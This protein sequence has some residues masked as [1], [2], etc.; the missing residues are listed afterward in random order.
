MFVGGGIGGGIVRCI[1]C[2]EPLAGLVS[3][4]I[5]RCGCGYF[6]DLDP[7]CGKR[8]GHLWRDEV[9]HRIEVPDGC[10]LVVSWEPE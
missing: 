6:C 5:V 4:L 7:R 10:L 1:N 3:R 2:G 9:G 8:Y